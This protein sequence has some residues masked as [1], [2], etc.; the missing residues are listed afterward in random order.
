MTKVFQEG[1]MISAF[2]AIISVSVL[3]LALPASAATVQIASQTTNSHGG[4]KSGIDMKT[5]IVA[6]VF[7]DSQYGGATYWVPVGPY[8]VTFYP[9]AGYSETH[10]SGCEGVVED[11]NDFFTCR[12]FY[13]DGAP[14]AEPPTIAP[15][16]VPVVTVP[17]DITASTVSSEAE[18]IA[19]L[20]KQIL[21]LYKI[22]IAL[23]SQKLAVVHS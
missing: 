11:P 6:G 16:V 17:Q 23:L 1:W 20:Q 4:G 18:Q 5:K 3:F 21:E 8:K 14:I 7:S 13:Q 15:A 2:I 19:A 22:L 9:P 12:V 10:D